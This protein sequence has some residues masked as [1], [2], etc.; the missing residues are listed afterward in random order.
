[1]PLYTFFPCRPDGQSVSFE[2]HEL[3]NDVAAKTFAL[4]VLGRHTSSTYVA[5]WCG[6]REVC[7]A[8]RPAHSGAVA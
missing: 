5:I 8:Q 3:A 2:S 1:M 4:T 7:R 6:E